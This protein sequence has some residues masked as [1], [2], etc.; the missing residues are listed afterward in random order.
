MFMLL[1]GIALVGLMSS[2]WVLATPTSLTPTPTPNSSLP[3][4]SYAN[5]SRFVYFHGESMCTFD[6][7]L[8]CAVG[9]K[10]VSGL[11]ILDKQIDQIYNVQPFKNGLPLCSDPA[12]VVGALGSSCY[13]AS[14]I[15]TPSPNP[16]SPLP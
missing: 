9:V 1:F 3:P 10:N 14:D 16:M 5:T 13:D 12:Y 4:S 2:I 15:L 6:P 11:A 7:N 8:G